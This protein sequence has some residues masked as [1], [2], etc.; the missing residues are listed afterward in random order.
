MSMVC[1]WIVWGE[2]TWAHVLSKNQRLNQI[3]W[4]WLSELM[5][6]SFLFG[7]QRRL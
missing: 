1:V 5:D 6:I 2:V 7:L 3:L 4:P